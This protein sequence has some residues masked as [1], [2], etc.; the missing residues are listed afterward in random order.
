MSRREHID[1]EASRWLAAR[2]A[3]AAS[4]AEEAAFQ[5]WIDADIRHRV[6][7]LR[8][9]ETWRRSDRLGELRPLD[10]DVDADLLR[11]GPARRHWPL[12]LAASVLVGIVFAGYLFIQSQFDWQHYETPVGGFSRIVLEDGSVID[13]N[14]DS[15]LKVRLDSK[16]REVH[17]LRGEGRFQVAHDTAR[18][19][20]VSAADADVRAVG[21]AFTVRLREA[22]RVDVVVSEG[23]VAIA[24]SRVQHSPPVKAGEVAVLL[25]DRLT[26]SQM[27]PQQIESRLAWTG[28][29]LQFR[30]ESLGDAVQEFNRYNRRQIR[31][32]DPSLADLRV[33]GTFNATD[34]ESFA[35]ALSGTFNLKVE[36][37]SPDAIVLRSP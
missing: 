17:L 22:Q 9:E 26:V 10:G 36:P 27:P 21:T 25:P 13:L 34:P 28:G 32:G 5:E 16:T 11:D 35:A 1:Q 4:A 2:D 7:Y 8:L 18:P 23:A 24:S 3:G 14:T 31:L 12:A 30:G 20:V 29:K 37:A 6:A 19:F 15:D 33:G